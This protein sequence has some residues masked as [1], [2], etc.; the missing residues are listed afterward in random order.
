MA[1]WSDDCVQRML[2]L[3]LGVP[4]KS[5][6]EVKAVLPKLMAVLTNYEVCKG[7]QRQHSRSVFFPPPFLAFPPPPPFFVSGK[8]ST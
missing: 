6:A 2:P 7:I 8:R 4:P 5:V 3:S 1:T